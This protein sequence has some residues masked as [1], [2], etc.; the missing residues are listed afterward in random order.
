MPVLLGQDLG[1]TT[2]YAW[3]YRKYPGADCTNFI[4]QCL[5]AGGW[6]DVGQGHPGSR[7]NLNQWWYT[8]YTQT[9]TWINAND[10]SR[11]T[12]DSI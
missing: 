1:L 3:F 10:W 11:F 7:A 12:L 5:S 6:F 9:Y 4:S 8:W 2:F